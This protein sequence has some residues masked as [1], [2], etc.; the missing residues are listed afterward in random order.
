MVAKYNK[1]KNS[2]PYNNCNVQIFA[3][4]ISSEGTWTRVD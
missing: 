4:C 1:P 2:V 3:I